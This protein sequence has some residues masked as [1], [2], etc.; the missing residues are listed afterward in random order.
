M[1]RNVSTLPGSTGHAPGYVGQY[2]TVPALTEL[3][4]RSVGYYSAMPNAFSVAGLFDKYSTANAQLIARTQQ[5]EVKSKGASLVDAQVKSV[6]SGKV[7]L[8]DGTEIKA[9]EV[10][11]C[12]GISTGTL[13]ASL[14]I[15]P[16]AHRYAYTAQRSEFRENKAALVRYPE[17]H[18]YA[19]D[20]SLQDGI[21]SYGRDPIA[22]ARSHLTSSA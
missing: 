18:V 9:A 16:V 15:V 12:T 3:A 6:E 7:I 1:D 4:K 22:V 17:A 19:R 2:N 8:S 10:V 13:L 21:G 5:A 20:H 11:L 14:R